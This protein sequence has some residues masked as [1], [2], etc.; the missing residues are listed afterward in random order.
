MQEVHGILHDEQHKDDILRA[1]VLSSR[2]PAINRIARMDPDRVFH[3]D[4]IRAMCVK[5]KLRFLDA[6]RF[7]GSIPP[8][9]IY[10]LRRLEARAEGH[11]QGFKVMAPAERFRLC[12]S[13]ADPLLFLPVGNDHYYLVHKWGKDLSWW[14][15]IWAWPQRGLEQLAITVLVLGL[16]LG[17]LFPMPWIEWYT[18]AEQ[19]G[20]ATKERFG[21]MV[22][23]S[24]LLAAITA[25]SWFTFG[26]TFSRFVWR[27]HKFD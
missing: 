5:Y 24:L 2:K 15:A 1:V 12:E 11:L 21:M 17:A 8:R 4:S 10:E 7:K 3:V 20:W 22:I 25:F 14:R 16:A 9:A 26:G 27:N 6:G 19:T 23:M 18:K 13:D